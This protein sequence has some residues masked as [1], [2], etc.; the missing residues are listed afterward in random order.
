MTARCVSVKWTNKVIFISQHSLYVSLSGMF[1]WSSSMYFLNCKNLKPVPLA[2]RSKAWVCGRSPAEIVGSNPTGG[3]DVCREY[4]L[5]TG[6]GLCDELITRREESYRLWCAVVCDLETSWVRRQLPTGG[7]LRQKQTNKQRTWRYPNFRSKH[8][9]YWNIRTVLSNKDNCV[10]ICIVFQWSIILVVETGPLNNVR[11]KPFL[12]FFFSYFF[13]F[14]IFVFSFALTFLESLLG[15]ECVLMHLVIGLSLLCIFLPKYLLR[16]SALRWLQS[17]FFCQRAKFHTHTK[18]IYIHRQC[19]GSTADFR[20][21][22][23]VGICNKWTLELMREIIERSVREKLR[24]CHAVTFIVVVS[25]M[26][27]GNHWA[28]RPEE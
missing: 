28:Q 10:D 17:V 15:E 18:R 11:M 16:T 9:S 8:V 25:G 5:L 3:M 24:L 6:R 2:A 14:I 4:S 20:W 26:E 1:I 13:F 23:L 12:S 7:L 19:N 27:S 22:H 21:Q